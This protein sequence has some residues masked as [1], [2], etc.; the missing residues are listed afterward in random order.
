VSAVLL[1][2]AAIAPLAVPMRLDW[3]AALLPPGLSGAYVLLRDGRPRYVGRSDACLLAR[4]SGHG[5]RGDATH[6][7]WTVCADAAHAF[8][9]ECHWY[10]AMAGEADVLNRIHPASPRRS[11]LACPF[12]GASARTA[13]DAVRKLTGIRSEGFGR[14]G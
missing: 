9:A 7:T 8:H 1:P 5:L 12:C 13:V 14:W 11:G 6:V 4:L 10:H 3:L 2:A